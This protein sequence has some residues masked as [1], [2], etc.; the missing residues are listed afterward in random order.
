[1]QIS[2]G[3]IIAQTASIL[4]ANR[5]IDAAASGLNRA[6]NPLR[7]IHWCGGNAHEI[8]QPTQT[9]TLPIAMSDYETAARYNAGQCCKN[10]RQ[11]YS[12]RCLNRR[13]RRLHKIIVRENEDRPMHSTENRRSANPDQYI[14]ESAT[15]SQLLAFVPR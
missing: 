10:K 2:K 15:V 12:Y 4:G 8:P 6:G 9:S 7:R 5:S 11:S 3:N 14:C 13:E 1:M